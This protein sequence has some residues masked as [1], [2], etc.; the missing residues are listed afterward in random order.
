[1]KPVILNVTVEGG[2]KTNPVIFDYYKPGS[3]S[4]GVIVTSGAP[5]FTL[6]HTFDD[7]W[8]PTFSAATANWLNHTEASM[9]NATASGDAFYGNTASGY[10][11]FPVASRVSASGTAASL[12]VTYIQAG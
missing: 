8:S 7:V 10:P 6:Q 9:L 11:P 4:I 12:Q 5:V 3:V 2:I 1:M